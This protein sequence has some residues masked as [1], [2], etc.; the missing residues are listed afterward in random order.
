MN[1]SAASSS[2][3]VVIPGRAFAL[4]IFIVRTRMSPAAAIWSSCSGVL[5]MIMGRTVESGVALRL[6]R[7]EDLAQ[8]LGDLGGFALARDPAQYAVSLVVGDQRLGLLVVGGK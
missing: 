4:R 7:G 2:S 8:F 1:F 5:R 3:S 6:R